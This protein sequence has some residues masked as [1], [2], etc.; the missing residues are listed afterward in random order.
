MTPDDIAT[1]AAA[2]SSA[3]VKALEE[4]RQR[5]HARVYGEKAI[6]AELGIS[7]STFWKLVKREMLP[8]DRDPFGISIRRWDV[9]R[10]LEGR[11]V[12]LEQARR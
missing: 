7:R 2:A 10:W 9:Q 4:E 12:A 11:R 3:A 5:Q 1:I 8:V 6:I